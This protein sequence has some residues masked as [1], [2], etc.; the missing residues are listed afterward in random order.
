MM[1]YDDIIW[2]NIYNLD[3]DIITTKE[4][5]NDWNNKFLEQYN[6]EMYKKEQI[7]RSTQIQ[8]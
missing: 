6:T 8:K 5:F 1:K 2:H 3:V 7:K 4:T